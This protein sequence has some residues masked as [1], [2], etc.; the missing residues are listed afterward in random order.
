LNV[1][2]PEKYRLNIIP[3][4]PGLGESLAV[5][6]PGKEPGRFRA[7]KHL[8]QVNRTYACDKGMR[9]LLFKAKGTGQQAN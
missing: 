6:T 3:R 9:G 7:K 4:E 1:N 5:I 2:D 8:L